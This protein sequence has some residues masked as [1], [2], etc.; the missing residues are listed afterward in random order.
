MEISVDGWYF[1]LSLIHISLT[2]PASFSLTNDGVSW[3]LQD[4]GQ[5][6]GAGIFGTL[7]STPVE[8]ELAPEE[9]PDENPDSSG[10]NISEEN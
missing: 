2:H 10:E 5:V 8:E 4:D 7:S 6:I 1:L 9:N 3:K